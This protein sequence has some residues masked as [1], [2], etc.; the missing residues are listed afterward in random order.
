MPTLALLL[1][2]LAPAP[3]TLDVPIYLGAELSE[4]ILVSALRETERIF[5][6]GG[7]ELR[8]DLSPEDHSGRS[9]LDVFVQP[10]P[11]RFKVHGCSR[12]RHD[13]RL[14]HTQMR[15]RRI[16]LWS[17]QVARAVDGNWDHKELPDVD[18]GVYCASLGTGS[19]SRAWALTAATEWTSRPG[20]DAGH[21]LASKPDRS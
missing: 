17:E 10:R 7:I 19:R 8:F 6:P 12:D 21:F 9:L 18:D 3:V 13:H 14:G 5:E 15:S 4:E 16:T 1:A 11:P 20:S 2:G